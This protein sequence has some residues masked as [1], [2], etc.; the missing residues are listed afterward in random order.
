MATAEITD[1]GL[2]RTNNEDAI[3][4][5]P[6]AGVFCVADGIGGADVGEEAS[7]LTVNM[8]YDVFEQAETI[9][10]SS[11]FEYR[12]R[13]VRSA[14]NKSSQA[15]QDY[16]IEHRYK[17]SGTTAV[18]VVFDKHD[19]RRAAVLHAGDSRAYRIRNHRMKLLTR[20]HTM[21]VE[22]SFPGK[23]AWAYGMRTIITR[24][25]G[26]RPFVDMDE[27][28][29]DVAPGDLFLLC[30]DGLTRMLGDDYISA[31][32]S[33]QGSHDLDMTLQKLV[34]EAN[35]AGGQDNIT[36]LLVRVD[37]HRTSPRRSDSQ[38][39]MWDSMVQK[40]S[41]WTQQQE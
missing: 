28:E 17:A 10:A 5:I 26:V 14:M 34:A 18:T 33:N 39:N 20:D 9:P 11:D 13:L 30:S 35:Y 8:L 36:A 6:Q 40:L 25:V 38:G 22:H 4:R 31:L 37:D 2:R 21:E 12:K 24:A 41:Q 16:C 23:D 29:I 7:A 1:L 19:P 32:I 3:I 15:I 27:T